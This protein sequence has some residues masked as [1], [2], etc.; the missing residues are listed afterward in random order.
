[1]LQS[2]VVS[3]L[4]EDATRTFEAIHWSEDGRI[5]CVDFNNGRLYQ[6]FTNG[7]VETLVTGIANAAG[8]GFGNDGTFYYSDL[9]RGSIHAYA[10]DGTVTTVATGLRQPTGILQSPS[11]D[12]LFVGEYA[13]NA[14][15]KVHKTTGGKTAF[16]AGS[17]INGPD[18]VI[19]DESGNLIVANFNNNVIHRVSLNGT[20]TRFAQLPVGGFSGYITKVSDRYYMPSFSG[21]RVYTITE[22]GEVS[23]FAGT[24]AAGN[25]DGELL[26]ATFNQP[27]GI[28]GNPSG[29]TILITDGNR[30][31]MV[32]GFTV[33]AEDEVPAYQK[34]ITIFPN[35]VQSSLSITFSEPILGTLQWK[36]TDTQGHTLLH[37]TIRHETSTCTINTDGLDPGVY[38]L[39]IQKDGVSIVQ[40]QFI[41]E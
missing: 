1:V 11:S 35:P 21:R 39:G 27:N 14:I 41:K 40:K 6:V 15:R 13:G 5:Y 38:I 18:A 20:I 34:T 7:E 23:L 22:D 37:D 28:I 9:T 2:Q 32:T 4:V 31:R 26:D 24:G 16:V 30:I 25:A 3:T 19:N 10:T 8:G 36:I 33:T 17:G 12:T 29:D